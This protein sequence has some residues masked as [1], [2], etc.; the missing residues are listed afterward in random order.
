MKKAIA[1]LWLV[2]AFRLM[3]GKSVWKDNTDPHFNS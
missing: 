1:A 3:Q 2:F